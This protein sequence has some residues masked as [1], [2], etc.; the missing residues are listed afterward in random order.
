MPIYELKNISETKKI[1]IWKITESKEELLNLASYLPY[2]ISIPNTKNE[3]RIKQ[4]LTTRLLLVDFFD[5]VQIL[6]DEFGKPYL[7][8]NWNI[9]IS[10][11]TNFVVILLNRKE[12]CGV[13][14]EKINSKV[15]RIKH[16]FLSE[17]DLQKIKSEKGLTIYWSAKEAL[18]K[19]YGKKEVLFIENLY[20]KDFN[21]NSNSNTFK[22]IIKMSDLKKEIKMNWEEIE[23]HILVYTV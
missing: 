19:Y 2:Q 6:Y 10:H 16:K 3:N 17:D 9:S 5:D 12:S 20:I 4:W 18:Y 23:D 22:G 13:D 14:I 1:G 21:F 11:T 15:E 8:N 7:A